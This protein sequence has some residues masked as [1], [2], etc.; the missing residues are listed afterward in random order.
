MSGSLTPSTPPL[1]AQPSFAQL[2]SVPPE[3]EWFANLSC[4]ATR[5]AYQAALADFMGF[6]GI[7]H[8]EDFRRVTRAHVIA[9]RDCLASRGLAPPSVR[10]RLAAL[11]SLFEYLCECNAVTHNP[12]KGV[13]RP[14]VQSYEGKTP[15]LGDH[16]ARSLLDAPQGDTLKALRD[17]AVLAMLLYHGLRRQELCNLTVTATQQQPA[18]W[19]TTWKPP[20]TLG[21]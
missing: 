9:W 7:A 5:R 14:G 17:R 15:A 10:H 20:A 16:Q 12:V 1:L 21:R 4:P 6:V 11:S 3:V 13:K 8:V 2:A 18:W 19:P